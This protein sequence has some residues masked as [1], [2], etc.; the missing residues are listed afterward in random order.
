MP[1]ADFITQL[2][3]SKKL[4]EK[5]REKLYAEIIEMSRGENP[6]LFF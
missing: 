4:T 2:N 6:K 5:N 3:D 1:S